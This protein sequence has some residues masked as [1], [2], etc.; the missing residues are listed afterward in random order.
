MKSG[1][2]LV[3]VTL[4]ILA[5]G[6][7][8]LAYM[9]A[10]SPPPERIALTERA[11]PVRVIIARTQAV[12]P[13]IV[14]FGLINPA[15][16]YEA[17]SQVGGTVEYVNPDLRKGAILPAG[18]VLVRLSPVDFNLAIAQATANIRAAEAR[19]AELTVS[20][21][22]QTSALKIE[23]QALALKSAE[24]E[25]SETLFAGGTIPQTVRDAAR[26]AHLV[27][28]QK[29]QAVAS[30][31]ALL[32]TQRAVQSEQIA[33]YQASLETAKL[34]LERTELTLP[35]PA[36][37]ASTTVEVG[38]FVRVGQTAAVLDGVEAAEVEAQVS[39]RALR[40]LI[41]SNRI[42]A[43]AMPVAPSRMTE[44]LGRMGLAANVHLRLGQDVVTWTASVDRI[45]DTIDQKTGTLGVI[46]R[47]DAAYSGME[48]GKRPPLTKG[49]FVEV[50]LKAQPTN[51]IAVPRSALRDGQ[52]LVA[53]A[54]NRL[55][56]VPVD[57]D[58]VQDGIALIT[59]GVAEGARIVVSTP[60]PAIAGMLLIATEDSDLMARL[61]GEG[62]GK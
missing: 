60:S 11:T 16:T 32:P 33:V 14:G 34:N 31:L 56:V 48:P 41:Q 55:Q 45:S 12:T 13:R 38:Q 52:L 27:Q 5:I 20:Q 46:V 30:T 6:A 50:T 21:A 24:L 22:N 17:I 61:A 7:G 59:D 35:F 37:V 29:V 36:R 4:P 19:L 25:R 39:I 28:R 42:S 57:F 40:G 54:A 44:A 8:V 1:F 9:V 51:G 58:L 18:A 2:K 3:F 49:M 47:V 26:T 62:R 23:Q 53:D 15:R 43:D 10:T